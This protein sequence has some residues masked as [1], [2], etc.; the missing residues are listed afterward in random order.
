VQRRFFPWGQ[1][2]VLAPAMICSQSP[3]GSPWRRWSPNSRKSPAFAGV[4][5][6]AVDLIT[7]RSTI[8]LPGYLI[9]RGPSLTC[10][11]P[12]CRSRVEAAA[13]SLTVDGDDLTIGDF[14]ERR[15]PTEKARLKFRRF[16][17]CQDRVEAIMRRNTVAHDRERRRNHSRFFSAKLRELRTKIIGSANHRA[18]GESPRY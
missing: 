12:S 13:E 4:L 9:G 2:V 10:E 5:G 17:R 6:W 15:D 18:H 16:D 3:F 14:L 11:W 8:D 7:L 1:H